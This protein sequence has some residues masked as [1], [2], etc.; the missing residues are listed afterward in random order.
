MTNISENIDDFD[1]IE[2]LKILW[3]QKI[4]IISLTSFFAIFSVFYALSIPNSYTSS[5]LLKVTEQSD[6]NNGGSGL[7]ELASRYG[8]LASIAGISM[9][10]SGVDSAIYAIEII[11]SRDFAKH[12][13]SF[14]NIKQNLM[15]VKSYD[16]IS[17]DIIYDS[18]IFDQDK[19]TWI[20][21]DSGIGSPEPSY[22]EVHDT[23]L[24]DLSA[25]KDEITGLITISFEHLSP[26]FAQ[27]FVS[28]VIQELNKITREIK[29]E[30]TNAALDYLKTEY[31]NTN[32]QSLKL[33]INALISNQMNNK[34]LASIR[35]DYLLSVIDP[36]VVP[37]MKSAPKRAIICILIT[38]F[39]GLFSIFIALVKNIR[40]KEI[41]E[42]Y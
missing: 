14:P 37:E 42:S 25:S 2:I 15:A 5:A 34:M 22:I 33:A 4:L 32:Q 7:S 11:K 35:D 3:S 31:E 23:A 21:K 1:I 28:L 18:K 26:V 19:N 30:E 6:N 16:N 13:M 40:Q 29:L 20:R 36:P 10:S 39:G 8:G 9:P 27:E 24:K 12:L 17:K 38:V 41:K